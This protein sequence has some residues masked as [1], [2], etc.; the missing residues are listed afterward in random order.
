MPLLTYYFLGWVGLGVGEFVRFIIISIGFPT[1]QN[2]VLRVYRKHRILN[3]LYHP[4]MLGTAPLLLPPSLVTF[5]LFSCIFSFCLYLLFL[6]R[7]LLYVQIQLWTLLTS[8]LSFWL[9]LHVQHIT[10]IGLIA[11]IE[12]F[13]TKLRIYTYMCTRNDL[14]LFFSPSCST[15]HSEDKSCQ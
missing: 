5:I 4:L 1:Q 14:F 10:A 3:V 2:L 9:V 6:R 12:L 8:S 13:A 7:L 11:Q 15:C